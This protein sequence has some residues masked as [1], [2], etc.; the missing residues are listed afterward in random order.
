MFRA[1]ARWFKAIGYLLT[2]QIDSA[3]R[4]LDTNPH[5]DPRQVRPD[6]PRQ[7]Q[8][9]PDLQAGR[10]RPH[11]PAGKQDRQGQ[12]PDRG[13]QQPRTPQGRRP[14]QGQAD[15]R[16]RSRK[17]ARPTRKS[18]PTRTTRSA[19][20]PT[21]T[22]PPRSP[23]SRTHIADLERDI[24]DYAKTIGDHKVQL[25]QLLRDV[26][27]LKAEAADA[28]ADIITAKQEK[29]LADMVAGIAK[30]GSAEELQR[31]R[32]M[33]QEIRAEARISK[34]IAG[35]DTKA[36][37]AEFLDYARQER[38]QQR[39]RL[40]WSAWRPRPRPNRQPKRPRPPPRTKA[41]P[42]RSR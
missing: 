40:P 24:A 42:C 26:D 36:Q 35:T 3:R 10:G 16:P 32:Q 13:G 9:D 23:K 12:G 4:V 7:D 29:D 39:V 15:R 18:T 21:T 31:M 8:P 30:D 5:V 37:E 2:G 22:S 14:R 38:G 27:K 28:V 17:P 11:R 34:E 41:R 19:W 25:Q 6:R 1:L 20:R 33:R